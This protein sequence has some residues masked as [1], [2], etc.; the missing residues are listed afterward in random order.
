[1]SVIVSLDAFPKKPNAGT[2]NRWRSKPPDGRSSGTLTQLVRDI[3][4]GQGGVCT[5]SQLL[6]ILEADPRVAP[7]LALAQALPRV[8]DYMKRSGFI[9]VE[10][11]LVRR[12]RREVG[13]PL[14]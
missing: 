1:M 5:R 2:P 4:A 8:L 3:L 13:R 6:H 14:R 7:G 10:G 12:R 11:E 9:E